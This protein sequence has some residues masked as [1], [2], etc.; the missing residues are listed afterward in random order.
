MSKQIP[1]CTG[2]ICLES[3][4]YSISTIGDFDLH[5]ERLKFILQNMIT[6]HKEYAHQA[7]NCSGSI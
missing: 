4:A 7:Y 2:A 1:G 3:H 6:Y 5:N